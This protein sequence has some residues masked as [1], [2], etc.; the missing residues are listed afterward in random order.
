MIAR[1]RLTRAV[2]AWLQFL[3][4]IRRNGHEQST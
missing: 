4:Q 1:N 3:S 2:T